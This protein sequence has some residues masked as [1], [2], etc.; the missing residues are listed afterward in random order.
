[1]FSR[2]V[3]DREYTTIPRVQQAIGDR[4]MCAKVWG[5]RAAAPPA[6]PILGGWRGGRD[7][8]ST[9]VAGPPDSRVP[10]PEGAWLAHPRTVGRPGRVSAPSGHGLA[11]PAESPG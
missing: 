10:P 8:A 4:G 3:H 6:P 9:L 7:G 11:A 1:M 2:G 5:G